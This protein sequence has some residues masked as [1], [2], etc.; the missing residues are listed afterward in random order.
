MSEEQTAT[1]VQE[2]L[3]SE[4]QAQTPDTPEEETQKEEKNYKEELAKASSWDHNKAFAKLRI[5]D[6]EIKTL[7]E[8]LDELKRSIEEKKEEGGSHGLTREEVR[9]IMEEERQLEIKKQQEWQAVVDQKE[10]ELTE[11]G[12]NKGEINEVFKYAVEITDGDIDKAYKTWEL[13]ND[14]RNSTVDK[15][16]KADGIV[17][18]KWTVTPVTSLDDVKNLTFKDIAKEMLQNKVSI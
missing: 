18:K 14:K 6:K 7:R 16:A 8:E 5:K 4:E 3:T 9:A 15:K 12:L 13:V 11:K 1:E 10:A 17:S 2:E